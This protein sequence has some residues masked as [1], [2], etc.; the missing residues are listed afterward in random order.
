VTGLL[1]Q[2]ANY[3]LLKMSAVPEDVAKTSLPQTWHKPRGEK[4]K[5]MS[6]QELSVVGYTK[7]KSNMQDDRKAVTST[8]S[9][10]VRG[11][12]P[13]MFSLKESLEDV[14]SN[15]LV[16][17]ALSQT[18][19]PLDTTKFGAF[20]RGSVLAVQQ[21]L[22][23]HYL[24]NLY[25][26]VDFPELP[27]ACAF[28]NNYQCVLPQ[29]QQNALDSL[30]MTEDEIIKFEKLTV[31]QSNSPL[32]HKLRRH[33]ITASKVHDIYVRQKDFDKLVERQKSTRHVQTAAMLAGIT[34]EPRAAES[35]SHLMGNQINVY[36]SGIVI[37]PWS[38]W[39]AVSPDRKVYDPRRYPV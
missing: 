9:N 8:L 32:W 12:F 34:N 6:V 16:M 10:P 3:K 15:A 22:H 2:V 17:A 39:M 29:F 25:D 13:S 28:R 1:Y 27:M 5:A 33:R 7:P 14:K 37:S 23:S 30:Y 38:P 4:I 19:P 35:Y 21:K 11:D 24:I 20:P 26:G 31:L 36:P 18:A